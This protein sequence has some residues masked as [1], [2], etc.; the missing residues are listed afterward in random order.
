MTE[1]AANSIEQ[2]VQKL[3][4]L[5]ALVGTQLPGISF[6]FKL[7]PPDFRVIGLLTSGGTIALFVWVFNQ[8]RDQRRRVPKGLWFVMIAIILAAVYGVLFQFLT[9]GT[10]ASRGGNERFQIGFGMC[11]ASLTDSA[12]T[13]AQQQHLD[14]PEDLMLA[15]GGYDEGARSRIWKGWSIFVSGVI[16]WVGALTI[17][18]QESYVT[19]RSLLDD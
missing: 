10:P 8:K 17:R 16:L 14:T 5:A 7:A 1:P 2:S 9:V 13:L 18:N 15:F 19:Q 3:I 6:Y 4:T 12:R 11:S